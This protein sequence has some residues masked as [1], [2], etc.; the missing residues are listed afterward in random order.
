MSGCGPV[1]YLAHQ[2]GERIGQAEMTPTLMETIMYGREVEPGRTG[3]GNRQHRDRTPQNEARRQAGTPTT[4]EGRI[5]VAI[6]GSQDTG[7]RPQAQPYPVRHL[8]SRYAVSA[9]VASV[10]AAELGMGGA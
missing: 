4:R 2:Q 6:D 1:G 5:D 9:A 10:I 8:V 7:N 3:W